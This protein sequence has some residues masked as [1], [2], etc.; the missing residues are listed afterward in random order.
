M[1]DRP[2]ETLKASLWRGW[3]LKT[4]GLGAFFLAAL[5]TVL[6]QEAGL[7]PD[8][9]GTSTLTAPSPNQPWNEGP[10]AS[11]CRPPGEHPQPLNLVDIVDL[12]LC[13]SPQTRQVW[14]NAKVAAAQVGV[15]RAAYLPTLSASASASRNRALE[16]GASPL[17]QNQASASLSL[18][19]LLFDFGGRDAAL[20]NARQAL[21]AANWSHDAVLQNV[22]LSAVQAYYQLIAAR[23]AVAAARES[24]RSALESLN[25]AEF[26]HQ[27][28]TATRADVLQARTAYSQAKLA[29]QSAEGN[30]RVAQG[31]LANVL[32][33]EADEPLA[34][35]SP[36]VTEP[37]AS[38]EQ[39]VHQ[40]VTAAQRSR[41]DLAAVEAQ[42]RAAAAAVA[43]A[44]ASGMPSV[45]LFASS[46]Y[47]YASQLPDNRNAALGVTV[48]IPL[49][50]GFAPTYRVR[51]AQ[52]QLEAQMAQRDLVSNQV[53]LDV[54]QAYQNL[55][56]AQETLFTSEDALVA[57]TQSEQVALGRYKAG[58]GTLLDLLSA[59]ASLA[60]ARQ[61]K[62]QAQYNWYIAKATLAKALGR[63]NPAFVARL[64][65]GSPEEPQSNGE[66]P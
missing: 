17:V 14:A 4:M 41:P 12:A 28:G 30:A 1:P 63:L 53:A 22:T 38:A 55:K 56:T 44:Q 6:A 24:E 11:P 15:S 60:N 62:V 37:V 45:S 43:S 52:E 26:R 36:R 47:N 23:E 48:A 9:F 13:H 3:A 49:F 5:S 16:S 7:P 35:A 64:N 57:A 61:Q 8:P 19:Y 27:V 10:K 32:G 31:V 18:N 40:L 21:A 46:G 65:S 33:E 2:Q 50:S 29:R 42:V 51:S 20:E 59:Q 58:V 39:G 34:V 66:K 25:A 54:W